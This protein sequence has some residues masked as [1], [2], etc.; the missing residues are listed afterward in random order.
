MMPMEAQLEASTEQPAR[1][2]MEAHAVVAMVAPMKVP[3]QPTVVLGMK[4]SAK[5]LA[6]VRLEQA[7]IPVE[8]RIKASA[9]EQMMVT[10]TLHPW[11]P[12]IANQSP[13][14]R[15]ATSSFLA[16]HWHLAAKPSSPVTPSQTL[17]LLS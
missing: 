3:T 16:Q 7:E 6:A 15:R 14:T 12:S 2:Q 9:A 10:P 11:R 13:K 8:A 17:L 4:A 5:E 1:T